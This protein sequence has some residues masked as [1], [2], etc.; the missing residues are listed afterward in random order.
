[1]GNIVIHA[2]MPKAGS[3]TIQN[4][5]KLHSRKLRG[6]GKVTLAAKISDGNRVKVKTTKGRHVNSYKI[7][8]HYNS[9]FGEVNND[10]TP[11]Y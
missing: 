2:G 6:Y 4:F 5:L 7:V 1:M 9:T 11:R 10:L 8:G 3:S